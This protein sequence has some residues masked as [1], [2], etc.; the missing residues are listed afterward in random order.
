MTYN[1]SILFLFILSLA[2]VASAM[3]SMLGVSATTAEL[4]TR[5]KCMAGLQFF[6][7]GCFSL[8][9]TY[10]TLGV[11]IALNEN[12]LVYGTVLLAVVSAVNF[13]QQ[14]LSSAGRSFAYIGNRVLALFCSAT[15]LFIVANHFLFFGTDP[16]LTGFSDL[17][18]FQNMYDVDGLLCEGYAI[19]RIEGS[20]AVYRCPTSIVYGPFSDAPFIPWPAYMEGRSAE[21]KAAQDALLA[22]AIKSH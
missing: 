6:A 2:Q 15:L 4:S 5:Q 22:N 14:L 21:L 19:V 1:L 7:L 10:M 3:K 9:F 16:N 12:W 11:G 8:S 17:G 13:G 18:Y 20:E